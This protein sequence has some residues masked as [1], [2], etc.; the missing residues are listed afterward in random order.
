[1]PFPRWIVA[2]SDASVAYECGS[3]RYQA[4]APTLV[5]NRHLVD[6]TEEHVDEAIEYLALPATFA[7]DPLAKDFTGDMSSPR[8]FG[9]GRRQRLS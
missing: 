3:V 5:V 6:R 2:L 9:N 4:T 8:V 1:L 7:T